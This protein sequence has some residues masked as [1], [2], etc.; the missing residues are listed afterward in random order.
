MTQR[1]L[2]IGTGFAGLWSAIGAAR[3]LDREGRS[4]AVEVALVGPKPELAIRPRLYEAGAGA[5]KA[6]LAELLE[7]LGIRFVQGMVET[8]RAEAREVDIRS[9]DG[10]AATLGYDRL[11]VATGSS[12]VHPPIPGLVE[13]CFDVDQLD[14]AARLEA[15]LHDLAAQPD[16][17]ARNTVV[18]AGGGF[19]GIEAAAEMPARL[20]GILGE[21]AA[22]RVVIVERAD[23]IGPDLGPGPRPVIL[24]AL[25][26]LG[27][28]MK[29][30]AAVTA[31]DADGVTTGTGEHIAAKTVIWIGGM[32]PNPLVRQIASEKD[33]L[34]RILVDRDLFVPGSDGIFATGDA[35]C[36]AT[37]D[38]GHHTLMSC[39]HAIGLGRSAGH[40]V[41]ASLLGLPS[42][43]Y[44][45]PHYVTCLD[46]GPWGAVFT[47]GWDRQI[48]LRGAE[49]KALKTQIN[50]QW[51]YPPRADRAEAFE[52][53]DPTRPIVA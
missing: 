40:N 38:A 1:I 41:A 12:V 44:S 11:V 19:S 20:R 53:A 4:D 3:V 5:F 46:L 22:I 16:S 9:D 6:P 10:A 8:I 49:A 50:T 47:E 21:D 39:Q 32:Q 31:V 18:V 2:V 25:H 15:H 30:G 26:D 27:V 43:P 52:Q 37:D 7:V 33:R 35:A 42:I 34:G 13:H 29:L 48:R 36:A 28:E 14:G 17:P 23:A 51:I 24:E 45:Q